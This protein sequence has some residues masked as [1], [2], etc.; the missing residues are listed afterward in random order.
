MKWSNPKERQDDLRETRMAGF[1]LK[2]KRTLLD[3]RDGGALSREGF[4]AR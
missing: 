2:S 3:K 1:V 4:E